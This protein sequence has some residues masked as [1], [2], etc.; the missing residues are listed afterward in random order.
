MCNQKLST[1]SKQPLNILII[2]LSFQWLMKLFGFLSSKKLEAV[3]SKQVQLI[4]IIVS[5]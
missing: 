4:S 2:V 5:I 1:K 3:L